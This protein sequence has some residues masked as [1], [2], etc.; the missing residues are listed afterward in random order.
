MGGYT[1]YDYGASIT[2]DRLIWREKYSEMKLQANLF[3]VSPAYLTATPGSVANG[4]YASTNAIAVTPLFGNGTRTNFYF[5][6]HA[7]F[8]SSNDTTYKLSVLTTIGNVTIPQLGGSLALYGRDAKI[9]VTDYV[10]GGINLIYSSGEIFTWTKSCSG[11]VAV[12]YGGAGEAHE[13]A[14]PDSLAKPSIPQGSSIRV[15]RKAGAWIIQWQVT[16]ERQVVS[17]G[18][19]SF[20]L[21]W[22]NEVYNY[23]TLDL[24]APAPISNYASPSKSSVIIKAGYLLRTASIDG[25][26]LRLTGDVNAIT[27]IEV[28]S[29]P[30]EVNDLF[31]NGEQLKTTKSS[32][33]NLLATVV[34][35]PPTI[36]TPDF[37]ALSW[38]YIDSLPEIQ[39]SYDDSLWT[40]LTH[41]TSNN[42][43]NTTTPTS[44]YAS[45]YG[46]HTGSLIYRSHFTSN[47]NESTFFVKI[48]GGDGFGHSIWL[49]STFLGSWAGLGANQSVLQTVSI[50]SLAAGEPHVLTVLIDHMGQDEEAPGTDQIKR[51]RGI[52]DY[53]LSGHS[54]SSISWKL[55]GN[56]G[57]EQYLDLARGP[58]NEGAMF[59]ER[60]GYHLPN[61]PSEKWASSSPILDGIKG[62][63]VGFYTTTFELDVPSGWDMPMNFVFNSTAGVDTSLERT[64][65]NYRVQFF[66]NG[67]QFGKYGESPPLPSYYRNSLKDTKMTDEK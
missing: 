66:V 35:T 62:A 20:Y 51:P 59:A 50:P 31:F 36:T 4:S 22:R 44:M 64:G 13:L 11:L 6:R 43:W 49:D 23:W 9:H 18:D 63:G 5:M 21:C 28:I 60:M 40:P 1:S 39:A 8:T 15:V 10:I 7:D 24:S 17:I 32:T 65:G 12:L 41:K 27:E 56:F 61:P 52:T 3:K 45:D 19:L 58:R 42:P 67:F 53:L 55:T 26:R 37:T 48:T 2:E 47:G 46:Y 33:G 16:P 29:T 14:V 34:F 30:T 38:K 54:L 57:G 25:N